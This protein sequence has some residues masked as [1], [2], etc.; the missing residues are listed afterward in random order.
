MNTPS[1]QDPQKEII[2]YNCAVCRGAN[3]RESGDI[4]THICSGVLEPVAAK[5]SP[6]DLIRVRF[7]NDCPFWGKLTIKECEWMVKFA[8]TMKSEGVREERESQHVSSQIIADKLYIYVPEKHREKVIYVAI[9]GG[10]VQVSPALTP[11]E[12]DNQQAK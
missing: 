9:D 12:R 1:P 10:T 11:E 2:G 8:T 5:D 4:I 7:L 3:I 6:H